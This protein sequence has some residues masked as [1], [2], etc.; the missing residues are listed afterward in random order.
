[1]SF[2][3]LKPTT[4]AGRKSTSP[5]IRITPHAIYL[6]QNL[7]LSTNKHHNV[8]IQA[9]NQAGKIRLIFKSKE[10]A[11]SRK[12]LAIKA[13][14]ADGKKKI[15]AGLINFRDI[16]ETIGLTENVTIQM[17]VQKGNE[18]IITATGTF[19]QPKLKLVKQAKARKTHGTK[20]RM[21]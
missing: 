1:M 8:E 20:I 13:A 12:V 19:K 2:E 17:E 18:S 4:S 16:M 5:T 11:S 6:N 10:T 9:D 15:T 14:K 21:A 7:Y 3:T